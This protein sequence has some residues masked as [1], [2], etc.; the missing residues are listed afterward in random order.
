MAEGT[1]EIG[2]VPEDID[3]MKIGTILNPTSEDFVHQFAG[4]D[5]V[6]PMATVEKDPEDARKKGVI[7]PGRIQYPLPVCI[8]IAKHL[9]EKI[10]RTENRER[11]EKIT[12]DKLRDEESRK[13]IP[14]YKGRIFDKM[15]ELVETDSDFFSDTTK[16]TFTR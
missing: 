4:K 1:V 7:V 10:I 11:I 6:V 8:H 15:K 16:D 12:D 14:N 13:S 9:A 2:Q 5:I 3:P